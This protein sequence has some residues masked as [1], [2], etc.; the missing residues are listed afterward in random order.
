MNGETDL[1][2]LLANM[3][4]HM[5]DSDYVFCSIPTAQYGDYADA[6]PLASYREPEGL[7]LVL[8][9]HRANK[10]RLS[11]DAIFKCITL[12]VHS[13][14]QAVGLTAAVAKKLT[15]NGISANVISAY[16]HDHIFVPSDR[17][18]DAMAALDEFKALEPA[19]H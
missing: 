16:Y 5:Q 8:E 9:I 11:Y 12:T 2:T 4:P 13:S 1:N 14:L 19:P 7:T 6:F 10:H 3:A 17:A 18:E 15:E